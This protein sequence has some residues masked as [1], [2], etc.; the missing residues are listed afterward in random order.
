MKARLFGKVGH[1]CW[2]WAPS[3][4]LLVLDIR[5]QDL[6]GDF[7]NLEGIAQIVGAIICMFTETF[8]KQS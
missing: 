4:E 6:C 2:E 5:A 3:G 7:I 8:E 1:V